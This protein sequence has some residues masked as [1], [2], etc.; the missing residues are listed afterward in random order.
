MNDNRATSLLTA[1]GTVFLP[2]DDGYDRARGT[3]SLEA[4]LRP[5]AVVYPESADQ[6]S[7]VLRAA[8]RAG[9]RVTPVG[10]GHNAH[11]LPDLGRTV[12]L[13]TSR[14]TGVTVDA[15]H[16]RARVRAGTT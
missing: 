3:W 4:D 1:A 7:A 5:A 10:T 9:L 14:L 15:A 16:R 12:M 6:I 8:G 2:G 13:R 11:P